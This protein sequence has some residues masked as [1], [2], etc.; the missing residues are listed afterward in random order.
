MRRRAR[1][2]LNPQRSPSARVTTLGS[3]FTATTSRPLALYGDLHQTPPAFRAPRASMIRCWS[4]ISC[5][6]RLLAWG[7][8]RHVRLGLRVAMTVPLH[9][10]LDL[11]SACALRAVRSSI[12]DGAGLTGRRAHTTLPALSGPPQHKRSA[13][14]N[15]CRTAAPTPQVPRRARA[16]LARPFVSSTGF[17]SQTAPND[18]SISRHVCPLSRGT[19][20]CQASGTSTERLSTRDTPSAPGTPRCASAP[21]PTRWGHERPVSF[22]RRCIGARVWSHRA[23]IWPTA[24]NH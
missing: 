5:S 6:L 12:V 23:E 11:V 18:S 2:H 19:R 24:L 1:R 15:H 4:A 3:L 22:Q 16:T 21:E 14:I 20:T 10:G 8:C 9:I 17:R 13:A 7:D